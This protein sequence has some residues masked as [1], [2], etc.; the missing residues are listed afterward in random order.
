MT[1]STKR[2]ASLLAVVMSL[3]G[4]K[5]LWAAQPIVGDVYDHPGDMWV[6]PLDEATTIPYHVQDSRLSRVA[7]VNDPAFCPCARPGALT[8]LAMDDR[9]VVARDD[10]EG[11]MSARRGPRGTSVHLAPAECHHLHPLADVGAARSNADP[12][13]T[14]SASVMISLLLLVLCALVIAFRAFWRLGSPPPRIADGRVDTTE[15]P[16]QPPAEGQAAAPPPTSG[17][18]AKNMRL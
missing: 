9:T 17:T 10:G 2:L 11:S 4:L 1:P 15:P 16:G 8:V 14:T 3:S 12:D 7:Q 6:R 5:S 13:A 18:R